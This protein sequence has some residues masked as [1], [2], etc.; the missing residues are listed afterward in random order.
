MKQVAS[1][2]LV[3]CLAYSLTMKMEATCSSETSVK[4]ELFITTENISL[5]N[6]A[7]FDLL[8][9]SNCRR[10][11]AE[12]APK[13]CSRDLSSTP[14]QKEMWTRKGYLKSSVPQKKRRKLWNLQQLQVSQKHGAQDTHPNRCQGGVCEDTVFLAIT[15]RNFVLQTNS[16]VLQELVASIVRVA[17]IVKSICTHLPNYM[18]P[19]SIGLSSSPA[20]KSREYREQDM[21]GRLFTAVRNRVPRDLD[22]SI[23]NSGRSTNKGT[24]EW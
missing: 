15:P 9:V 21:S 19:H 7:Y 8:R 5:T 18:L 13:M 16:K 11:T 14:Q 10:F 12:S 6:S 2:D 20:H 17:E 3:S 1:Q 4:I 23:S 24:D 22:S